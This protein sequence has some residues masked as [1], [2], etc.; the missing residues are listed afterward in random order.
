MKRIV[1]IFAA[2]G[3]FVTALFSPVADAVVNVGTT[4]SVPAESLRAL[5]YNFTYERMK[6][7]EAYPRVIA[8]T[9][10]SVTNL[11]M[12]GSSDFGMDFAQNPRRFLPAHASDVDFYFSG[13]GGTQTLTHAIELGAIEA[14]LR[15]KKVVLL[16]SPQWFGRQGMTQRDL[17]MT[18]SQQRWEALV[19]NPKVTDAT[20]R[21]LVER[22][23]SIDPSICDR[24]VDCDAWNARGPAPTGIR[25]ARDALA[26]V[27]RPAAVRLEDLKETWQERRAIS[28]YTLPYA[29]AEGLA[30]LSAFDWAAAWDEADAQGRAASSNDLFIDDRVYNGVRDIIVGRKTNY[31]TRY[32]AESPGYG[33]LQLF[34]DVARETG[35]EMLV[36]SQPLHAVWMDRLGFAADQR[37]QHYQRVRDVCAAGGPGVRLADLSE[38]EYEPYFFGDLMHLGRKGWLLVTRSA[39]EFARS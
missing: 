39:Y 19:A 16:A 5:N 2:V 9:P 31:P 36:V 10:A 24:W 4:L 23:S 17:A 30:P 25:A 29:Q 18:F 6:G 3:V 21:A 12:M 8:A 35:V 20:K 7:D 13:R 33:D 22:L 32:W 28:Q 38:W 26:S 14:S 27:V 34:L 1:A 11:Y 37:A 15:D